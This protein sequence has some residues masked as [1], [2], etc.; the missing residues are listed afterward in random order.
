MQNNTITGNT[1]TINNQVDTHLFP[2]KNFNLRIEREMQDLPMG[3]GVSVHKDANLKSVKVT[4][5]LY[6]DYKLSEQG[7]VD[8]TVYYFQD[9]EQSYTGTN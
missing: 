8:L 6:N 1:V 9:I 2:N 5:N 7:I 4:I 3:D